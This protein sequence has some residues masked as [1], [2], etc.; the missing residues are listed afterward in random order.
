[1][2]ASLE[3]RLAAERLRT[4]ERIA[5]LDR[6]R[7]GIID[8]TTSTSMDDEHDPEGATIAFE[9]SQIES[10]LDQ[11]R[12]HLSEL[13]RALRQLEE[14]GY[15]TC[16]SCGAPIGDE[17]LAARPTARTCITCATRR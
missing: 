15:G 11:S 3:E 16:E 2:T 5:A 4:L 9:R 7:D 8:S 12:R 10:L 14:G 13:D 1:M 17:R 6:D